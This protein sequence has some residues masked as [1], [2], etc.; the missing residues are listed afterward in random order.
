MVNISTY[1]Q[2]VTCF[3]WYKY[4]KFL[5]YS[6]Q[7]RLHQPKL[8]FVCIAMVEDFGL[9]VHAHSIRYIKAVEKRTTLD[10]IPA[11]CETNKS[12]PNVHTERHKQNKST[13]LLN[14]TEISKT[15]SVM[16]ILN[17][18]VSHVFF[19]V[20]RVYNMSEGSSVSHSRNVGNSIQTKR[21][22]NLMFS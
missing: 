12:W 21:R 19:N 9:H 15:R 10:G 2:N 18:N 11:Q 20:F 14:A 4:T 1:T 13:C 16:R 6:M 5:K 3:V 22:D 8:C 17:F 7:L